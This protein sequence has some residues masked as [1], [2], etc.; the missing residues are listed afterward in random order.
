[1]RAVEIVVR[2]FY[3]ALWAGLLLCP[4]WYLHASAG[5]EAVRVVR[6]RPFFAPPDSEMIPVDRY[7][8]V[9]ATDTTL[10]WS[11]I[12]YAVL[13]LIVLGFVGGIVIRSTR[14]RSPRQRPM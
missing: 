12:L 6:F 14:P 8:I 9:R 13:G 2:W 5:D 1:M 11:L 7:D 4:P 3:L 10:A